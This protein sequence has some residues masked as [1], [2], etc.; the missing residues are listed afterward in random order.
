MSQPQGHLRGQPETN[1]RGHINAIS[2]MREE[3]QESLVIVLQVTVL[4]P[5]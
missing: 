2:T 3:L 5:N 1:P 4:V